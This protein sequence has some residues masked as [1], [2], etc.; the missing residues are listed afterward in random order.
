[1]KYSVEFLKRKSLY[2]GMA[3]LLLAAC[4]GQEASAPDLKT[5]SQACPQAGKLIGASVIPLLEGSP[6]KPTWQDV[7]VRGDFRELT[8]GCRLG[9]NGTMETRLY[10]QFTAEKTELAGELKSLRLPYFIAVLGPQE[11]ILQKQRLW[12]KI[13]FDKNNMASVVEE[14]A[15]SLPMEASASPA[16]YKI[17]AGFELTKQQLDLVQGKFFAK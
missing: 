5:A 4:A 7:K 8:G 14:Q 16:S 10:A 9:K 17:V 12:V 3:F 15:I 13:D 2:A 6:E 11:E 1:M